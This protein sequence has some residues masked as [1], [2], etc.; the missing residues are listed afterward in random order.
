[1]RTVF[2]IFDNEWVVSKRNDHQ[3]DVRRQHKSAFRDCFK[4]ISEK[5]YVYFNL[6]NVSWFLF[7]DIILCFINYLPVRKLFGLHNL[8]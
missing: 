7:L 5:T 6:C 1:M 2:I 4:I 3:I 8:Y